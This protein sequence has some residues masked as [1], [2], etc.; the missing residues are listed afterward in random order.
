MRVSTQSADLKGSEERWER[1][2][3]PGSH[4]LAVR[5]RLDGREQDDG[6][7]SVR[8]RCSE[9]NRECGLSHGA[10]SSECGE[11]RGGGGLRADGRSA[12]SAASDG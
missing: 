8:G 10:Q 11:D 4:V 2:P 3:A 7:W 12:V 5:T 6:R 1:P 9:A